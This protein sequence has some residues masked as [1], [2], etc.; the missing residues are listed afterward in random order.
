MT[1]HSRPPGGYKSHSF[2]YPLLSLT[3]GYVRFYIIAH[4]G[5]LPSTVV[6]GAMTQ[7]DGRWF[8]V[9]RGYPGEGVVCAVGLE[10][11][12]ALRPGLA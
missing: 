1:L 10:V 6:F 9:R 2:Y 7:G 12:S 3:A 4:T 11:L 8:K 5:Q